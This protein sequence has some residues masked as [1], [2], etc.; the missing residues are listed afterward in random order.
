MEIDV[1]V[2][3]YQSGP[4]VAQSERLDPKRRRKWRQQV[5]AKRLD[6]I[7][8][9]T[10][11]DSV[12]APSGMHLSRDLEY[13]YDEVLEEEFPAPEGFEF[14]PL[15]PSVP[16]GANTHTVRRV[17]KA[18][19]ARVYRGNSRRTGSVSLSQDEKPYQIRHYVTEIELDFFEEKASNFSNSSIRTRL[20][21]AAKEALLELADDAIWYGLPE[22]GIPG[23]L[24]YLFMPKRY[25]ATKFDGTANPSDVLSAL[26][27]IANTPA[28]FSKS[29]F[30]P[31]TMLV[32]DR[33]RRYLVTEGMGDSSGDSIAERFLRHQEEIDGIQGTYELQN[34]D[35]DGRDGI[36]C[37]KNT[38]RAVS[39]V[40]PTMP[41]M[42]PVERNGFE[43]TIP[44]YMTHGGIIQRKP[45]NNVLAV[46][47]ATS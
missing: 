15:D 36:L 9:D 18:G 17:R 4:A 42:L 19:N 23:V 31:D 14:F 37:Y 6:S 20:E 12:Q 1:N 34:V 27:D 43:V 46:V 25:P 41:T 28:N 47:E 32:S 44:V 33:L 22:D 13:L 45:L 24:Q 39:N 11:L 35:G 2:R 38:R 29:L 21:D 16:E 8:N 10:R 5:N 40:V 26:H 30:K 7:A 3:E